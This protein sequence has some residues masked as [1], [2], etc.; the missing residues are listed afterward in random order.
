MG[1][2]PSTARPRVNAHVTD[3]QLGYVLER[4]AD[5]LL[6]REAPHT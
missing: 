6:G 1:S 4:A 5:V 3:A 2:S